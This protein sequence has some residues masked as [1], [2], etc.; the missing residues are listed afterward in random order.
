MRVTNSYSPLQRLPL[1]IDIF[2][3]FDP[4]RMSTLEHDHDPRCTIELQAEIGVQIP[5][6]VDTRFTETHSYVAKPVE[7]VA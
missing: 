4:A 2:S 6:F 1:N 7:R 3:R 5:E